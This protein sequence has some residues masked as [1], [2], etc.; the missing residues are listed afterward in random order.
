MENITIDLTHDQAL[1]LF[2]F[3]ARFNA[4]HN[5]EIFEDESEQKMLWLIEGQLERALVEPF[6][7]NYLD[8]IKEARDRLRDSEF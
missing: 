4:T 6:W 7:P 5:T 2:E 8:I 1:V 3:L